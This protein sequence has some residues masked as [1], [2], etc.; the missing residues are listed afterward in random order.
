LLITTTLFNPIPTNAQEDDPRPG[1]L[2][3]IGD[4]AENGA[5]VV[6]VLIGSPA[7]VAGIQIDDVIIAI[8]ETPIT[9]FAELRSFLETT[10]A[11]DEVEVTILRG[12][13]TLK[14]TVVLGDERMFESTFEITPITVPAT[15]IG[16]GLALTDEGQIGVEEIVPDS[17]ADQA[18]ILV[19]DIILA[20][21]ETSL[22]DI[23]QFVELIQEKSPGNTV[24]LTILRGEES[25]EI[26]VTLSTP[27]NNSEPFIEI[28]PVTPENPAPPFLPSTSNQEIEPFQ[29]GVQYRSLTP[30]IALS[31]EL[32][33]EEG[34]LI[35]DVLPDTPAEDA[36][37]L[38]DDI[39]V[40]VDG[41]TVDIEHTLSDRLYAYEAEDRVILTV[42]RGEETLEIGAV[43][44]ANHPA[45][46]Q[47]GDFGIISPP[48]MPNFPESDNPSVSMPP[49][50][51]FVLECRS[52]R[53]Q[54]FQ[55]TLPFAMAQDP[56]AIIERMRQT[57]LE[58][59]PIPTL[60]EQ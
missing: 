45:K 54:T 31:L 28:I 11:G 20:V 57:G 37:L 30:E 29:L 34:A 5:L 7:D 4:D 21:D 22:T 46:R 51:G 24:I 52:E 39:I 33:I 19:G 6:N 50:R 15:F 18:D 17:P 42:V 60:E 47:G 49:Q 27:P 3:I 41:D 9:S 38:V 44:A 53:G 56:S 13:E 58:C 59:Y 14:F 1:R 12:E 32:S 43:L 10:Q 36:G 35:L 55:I 40:A 2:G 48:S 25:L 26:P 8:N 16:I 23:R